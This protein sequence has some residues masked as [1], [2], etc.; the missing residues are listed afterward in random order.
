ME[1]DLKKENSRSIY[2]IMVAS[3][4]ASA[5]F[6]LGGP[7]ASNLVELAIAGSGSLVV[8][9][10][11]VMIA[12]LLPQSIKHKLVFTRFKNELPGGR[13]DRLC[14][15]DPRLEY[16]LVENRWPEVFADDIDSATRNSRWYQQIYK[17]VKDVA[18][19]LQAHRSF[20]LY[21]DTFTGLL[22]VLVATVIWS[23]IG[24]SSFLG[25]V[26]SSVFMVQ[27]ALVIASL[28]AARIAGNRFVVNAVS[29]AD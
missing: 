18:E 4:V 14:K 7:S 16:G 22:L 5:F 3:L 11:L 10:V 28:V 23:L 15:N 25:Q 13:V 17:P 9:A 24:E 19:V 21:R 8:S 20:L 1:I 29:A 12:N 27:G 6:Q 2:C 26:K